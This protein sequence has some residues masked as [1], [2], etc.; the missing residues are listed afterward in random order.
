MK[1]YF[2]LLFSSFLI[3][4]A[5][6]NDFSLT[7]D[8]K[9]EQND[10]NNNKDNIKEKEDNHI[11]KS[12]KN[13]IEHNDKTTQNQNTSNEQTSNEEID[14]KDTIEDVSSHN[15]NQIDFS[16]IKDKSTLESIIYGNYSEEQK[17]QAYNSAVAN[18]IIPQGNVMEGPAS[19]AYQSSLRVENGQE[20][21]IYDRPNESDVSVNDENASSDPNAEINAAETE[22]EY[23]DALRKKYNGGLSSGEIQT[24]H[25]IEQGYYEGD[26]AEEVYQN[27]KEQ[28]ADIV[29]GKWDKYKN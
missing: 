17:I 21:S 5:C 28:E 2:I 11:S 13:S 3:L 23:Y 16:N 4:S 7:G 25:A 12:D 24:K 1:R 18:G 6:D 22:D 20:K 19:V 9:K 26:D 10:T 14:S 8:N 27:I 15:N 29:A